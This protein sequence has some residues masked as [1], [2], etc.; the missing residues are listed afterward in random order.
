[1]R[2]VR[3]HRERPLDGGTMAREERTCLNAALL[4]AILSE[5]EIAPETVQHIMLSRDDLAIIVSQKVVDAILSVG[6]LRGRSIEIATAAL[7]SRN[8]A[9]SPGHGKTRHR[10]AL[11]RSRSP[12]CDYDNNHKTFM[13]Q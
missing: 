3:G 13:D 1:M 4:D 7:A 8:R 2:I 9:R 10:E 5:Y 6:P 11:R 12:G